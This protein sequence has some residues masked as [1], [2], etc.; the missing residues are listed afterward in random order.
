MGLIN[1]ITQQNSIK[2][3]ILPE[4]VAQDLLSGRLPKIN[5]DSIFLKKGE[6]CVYIDKAIRNVEKTQR[7]SHYHG[8]SYKGL[9]G[10]PVRYGT[11]HNHEYLENFQY[12]GILYITN[13]RVIFQAQDKGFERPHGKLTAIETFANAIRLQYGDSSFELIVAD[14]NVVNA[15]LRLTN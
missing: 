6:Y 14:G 9:L 12:K 1:M 11:S 3:S 5:T 13:K 4:G 15:A 2:D 10:Q 7:V 8:S